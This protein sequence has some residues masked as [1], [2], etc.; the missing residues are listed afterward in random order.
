MFQALRQPWS[1][2]AGEC[3]R[4]SEVGVPRFSVARRVM[5]FRD[6]RLQILIGNQPP[7]TAGR[8]GHKGVTPKSSTLKFFMY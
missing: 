8:K 3:A 4:K 1:L 2:R 5:D 6:L 7:R